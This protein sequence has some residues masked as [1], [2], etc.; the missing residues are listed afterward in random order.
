M[1]KVILGHS[2]LFTLP[3]MDNLPTFFPL[4]KNSRWLAP[5]LLN[6]S[7]A[8]D[9]FLFISGTVAAYS[10][11]K[12][13]L[14]RSYR[15]ARFSL[16]QLV[17]RLLM[18]YFHRILRIW[19]SMLAF[20]L[21]IRFI[22]NHL[23]DGPMWSYDGKFLNYLNVSTIRGV[24]LVSDTN[25]DLSVRPS[26][27][28]YGVAISQF[29]LFAWR[30]GVPFTSSNSVSLAKAHCYFVFLD[31]MRVG[32]RIPASWGEDFVRLSCYEI[33]KGIDAVNRR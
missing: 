7:L 1:E 21:F 19:P 31:S 18:F 33:A 6:S 14:F 5:V 10:M 13:L 32:I 23:G 8:V 12:R 9:S 2:T 17:Y 15:D 20:T 24:P 27:S 28:T 29:A 25:S 22:Y 30:L 26:T 16:Y 4:L 3:Y 11:R